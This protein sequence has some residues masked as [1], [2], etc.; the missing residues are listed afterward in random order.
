V[1][2]LFTTAAALI[3]HLNAAQSDN[4]FLEALKKYL[5][6]RLR[7]R[8]LAACFKPPARSAEQPDF[9]GRHAA[10]APHSGNL[11]SKVRRGLGCC[12]HA[13]FARVLEIN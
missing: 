11:E 2:T 4:S 1:S 7:A 3:N 9:Q 12:S 13:F 5:K 6:S 8:L 10:F